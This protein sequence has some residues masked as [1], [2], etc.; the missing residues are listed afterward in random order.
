MPIDFADLR[1]CLA[2]EPPADLAALFAARPL[3]PTRPLLTDAELAAVRNAVSAHLQDGGKWFSPLEAFLR[4]LIDRLLTNPSMNAA[5]LLLRRYLTEARPPW[6]THLSAPTLLDLPDV[7]AGAVDLLFVTVAL[8]YTLTVRKPPADLNAENV[9]AYVGYTDSYTKEHGSWGISLR[10]WNL[11]CAGGCMFLFHTLKFQPER[12]SPDFLVLRNRAGEYRTLLRGAHGLAADGSLT[13]SRS[14]PH[15]VRV[16]SPLETTET[17]YIAHEVLP[18]GVVCPCPRTF[19]KDEWAVALDENCLMLGMHIPSQ[20]P[21]TVAE[22]RTSMAQALDFYA[23]FLKDHGE[24]C[25]FVCYPWLYS[26]QNK[27]L[28]PPESRILE[29]QRHVHLCPMCAELDESLTFLRPGSA[30]QRRLADF[31]AAGNAY[32]VG[33]MYVPLDEARTFGRFRHEL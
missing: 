24:I 7:D 19:P 10:D 29:M 15:A 33:Y 9:G 2:F 17:G 20:P 18:N 21:Y 11:L 13:Q 22:H 27:H 16:T 4:G 12:F 6:E 1:P 5:A 8:A 31:R 23:T 25:G 32:H 30:L 28:L 26:A 14:D 3:D